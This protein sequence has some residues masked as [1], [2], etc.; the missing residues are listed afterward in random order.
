M[1]A[2]HLALAMRSQAFS[3][4]A[5]ALFARM[6]TPP[7]PARKRLINRTIRF[8][9]ATDVWDKLD[10]LMVFAAHD[11][12]AALLNWTGI[13]LDGENDGA[14]FT[15]DRGFTGDGVADCIDTNV[16]PTSPFYQYAQ[17]SASISVWSRT[18]GQRTGLTMGQ[19]SSG[20][21]SLITRN[22]SDQAVGSIN[23]TSLVTLAS[24][25]T[26]GSGLFTLSRTASNLTTLYRNGVS[27]GSTAQS[28]GAEPTVNWRVMAEG[29]SGPTAEFWEGEAAASVIAAGLTADDADALYNG[30]NIYMTGVG[31]A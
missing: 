25:V 26:D 22:G 29:R 11:S 21:A 30:L 1:S 24:G 2:L 9:E 28:A 14:S 23:N 8:L 17:N 6:T 13:G 5:E 12:Q 31:A 4:N 15:Q 20:R 16:D 27:I 7:A 10:Q 19:L 3:P 18:S